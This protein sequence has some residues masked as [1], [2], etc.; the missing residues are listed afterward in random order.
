MEWTCSR[1]GH[2]NE[3]T[4]RFCGGC[5]RKRP[6]EPVGAEGGGL[7]GKAIFLGALTAFSLS[8]GFGFV[9]GLVIVFSQGS[10]VGLMTGGAQMLMG[11]SGLLSV[12]I[13]GFVAGRRAP[14]SGVV[15]G[16]VVA[17][18]AGGVGLL[19]TALVGPMAGFAVGADALVGLL[20]AGGIGAL[21]GWLGARSATG[22]R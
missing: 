19:M 21:G 17:V 15:N 5:G 9:L 11:L 1:C 2:R 6:Q 20:I 12:L 3:A 18:L 7:Q 14:A 10:M 22:A 8:F 4:A 13:G 16:V